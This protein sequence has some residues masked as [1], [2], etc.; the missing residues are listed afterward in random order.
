MS[1]SHLISALRCRG[2]PITKLGKFYFILIIMKIIVVSISFPVYLHIVRNF[3]L[4]V[5]TGNL[6]YVSIA[7]NFLGYLLVLGTTV[8]LVSLLIESLF[9]HQT[10][11]YSKMKEIGLVGISH[12]SATMFLD[13]LSNTNRILLQ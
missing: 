9:V 3:K 4:A 6:A 2:N 13:R 11:G 5:Q 10:W 7:L 1:F 8:F 12:S